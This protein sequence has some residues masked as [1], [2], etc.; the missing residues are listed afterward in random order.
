MACPNCGAPSSIGVNYCGSCGASLNQNYA[1]TKSVPTGPVEVPVPN[2]QNKKLDPEK[3]WSEG[4]SLAN[5]S[6]ILEV[7]GRSNEANELKERALSLYFQALDHG[8]QG[9]SEVMCRW[10]LGNAL[11]DRAMDIDEHLRLGKEPL[12][13]IPTLARGVLE[14]EKAVTLDSEIGNHVFGNKEQQSDLRK[15]DVVWGF[16]SRFIKEHYGIEPALSYIVEKIKLIQHLR[17]LL[18]DLFYSFGCIYAE[19][20][21]MASA[22]DM[23][24][25]ATKAEDYGDVLD[26]EDW[27]YRT[28]QVT[29]KN[30]ANNLKYLETYGSAP[31]NS[32]PADPN[33]NELYEQALTAGDRQDW[34]KAIELLDACMCAKPSPAVAMSGFFNLAV[35]IHCKYNFGMR[36]GESVPDDEFRWCCRMVLCAA[37]AIEIYETQL[38]NRLKGES[39][40]EVTTIY[41]QAKDLHKSYSVTYGV[42]YRDRSGNVGWRDLKKVYSS[43][44][45][46]LAC[47]EAEEKQEAA[48]ATRS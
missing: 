16:Q 41:N 31:S 9:K 4:F 23:L 5:K 43:N 18:P 34:N 25:V 33:P 48:Q 36:H 11:Y 6:M 26:H 45:Y 35:V 44:I 8:L 7:E 46:P 10:L 28:A 13:Q 1:E 17:V 19:A 42:T 27:T 20:G 15:L 12:G 14:L 2:Q 37:K 40:E 29:K 21:D 22:I 32:S 30:A 39:L 47:I 38:A 24:R 3:L